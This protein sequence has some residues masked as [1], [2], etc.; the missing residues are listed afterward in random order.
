VAHSSPPLGVRPSLS[1]FRSPRYRAP[2]LFRKRR[3]RR[4]GRP[5]HTLSHS[6]RITF[7]TVVAPPF[8]RSLREGGLQASPRSSNPCPR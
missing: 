4:V 5:L 6:L 3:E 1:G 7:L 2:T 8:P